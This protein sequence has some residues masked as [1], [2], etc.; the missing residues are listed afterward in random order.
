[1]RPLLATALVPAV[2]CATALAAC[3]EAQIDSGKA[4]AAI[5]R[6]LTRQTGIAIRSVSCPDDVKVERGGRF[7]CEAVARNG[8]RAQVLVTQRDDD[9]TVTWRV[10]PS[11]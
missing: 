7:R 9:G 11:R 8:D 5:N 6:G 2:L 10:V 3:G 4:E 1:M